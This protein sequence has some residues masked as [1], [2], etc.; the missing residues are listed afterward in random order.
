MAE[1]IMGIQSPASP[2]TGHKVANGISWLTG[3]LGFVGGLSSGGLIANP[4]NRIA[5]LLKVDQ[6]ATKAGISASVINMGLYGAFLVGLTAIAMA[7]L[8]YMGKWGRPLGSA[9]LGFVIG[10]SIMWLINTFIS[11]SYGLKL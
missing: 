2:A 8:R 11:G 5:T 4:L 10:V 1:K 9:I 6:I 3:A 7:I